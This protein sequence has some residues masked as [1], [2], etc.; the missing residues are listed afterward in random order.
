MMLAAERCF[1]SACAAI[2]YKIQVFRLKVN[3]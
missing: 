1:D 3:R 2:S